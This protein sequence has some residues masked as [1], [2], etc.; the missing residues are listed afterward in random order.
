MKQQQKTLLT[1]DKTSHTTVSSLPCSH[2]LCSSTC[3]NSPSSSS[4]SSSSSSFQWALFNSSP[5][6]LHRFSPTIPN[7]YY[8]SS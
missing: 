8:L 7:N 2:P 4:S 5:F 3:F 6:P 1:F